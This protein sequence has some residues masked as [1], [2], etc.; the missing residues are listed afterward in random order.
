MRCRWWR[1][2]E[3]EEKEGGNE[4]SREVKEIR[5]VKKWEE[6]KTEVSSVFLRN[7]T[8]I[9]GHNHSILFHEDNFTGEPQ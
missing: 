9:K 3:K 8:V 2:E 6:E 4:E 5:G 7:Q 1:M